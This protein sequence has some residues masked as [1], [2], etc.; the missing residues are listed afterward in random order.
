MG[1]KGSNTKFKKPSIHDGIKEKEALK[2]I[3]VT[4][5]ARDP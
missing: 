5:E 2:R 4:T 1:S 3:R